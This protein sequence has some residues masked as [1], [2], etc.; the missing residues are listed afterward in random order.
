MP[1]LGKLFHKKRK[2]K[3]STSSAEEA[4]NNL[5]DIEALLLKKQEHYEEK[6]AA[7]SQNK[8]NENTVVKFLARMPISISESVESEYFFYFFQEVA[9]AKKHGTKNKKLAL[10]ALKRKKHHERELSRIDGVLIK[11]EAQR[12]A[13]EDAGMNME[14]LGVLSQTTNAL[15]IANQKFDLDKVEE[16]MDEIGEGLQL[17]DE[18]S[19]AISRPIGD[20]VDEDELLGELEDLEKNGAATVELPD[21]PAGPI[22]RARASREKVRRLDTEMEE[23]E[24]WAAAN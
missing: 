6:I 10:A 4:I 22:T 19:T 11:I 17:S 12:T 2:R 14:V 20:V 16:L 15:R 7:T 9:N 24:K 8:P 23:L 13:L 5:R 21:A 3:H 18:F 1:F